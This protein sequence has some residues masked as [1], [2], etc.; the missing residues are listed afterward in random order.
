LINQNVSPFQFVSIREN[1]TGPFGPSGAQIPIQVNNLGYRSTDNLLYAVAMP[2]NGN[3]NYGIIQ[4]DSNGAVIPFMPA[5]TTNWPADV[6]LLAGDISDDG[7]TFYVNTY[8]SSTLYIVDL[9]TKTVTTKSLTGGPVSVADWAVNPDNGKLYGAEGIRAGASNAPIYELDPTS[10]PG[11]ITSLGEATGLPVNGSGNAAFYGGAWFNFDGT[12]FVYRNNDVIYEI[13]LSGPSVADT[14]PG[15]AGPSGLNDAAACAEEVIEKRPGEGDPVEVGIYKMSA[16]QLSF[17]INYN[18]PAAKIMDLVPAEFEVTE[19][20]EGGESIN[21]DYYP[22]CDSKNPNKTVTCATIIEWDV[23]GGF[24]S[25]EC[26][27]ETRKSNGNKKAVYK[28]TSCGDLWLN[29]GATA[30]QVDGDG[31]LV[32]D[33]GNPIPIL[34]TSNDLLVTAVA[35][36][37]P[38]APELLSV[39]PG[40]L[41]ELLLEWVDNDDDDVDKYNIYRSDNVNGPFQSDEFVTSVGGDTTTYLDTGL[42]NDTTYC[43]V[44]K[45][46]YADGNEGNESNE[47]CATTPPEPTP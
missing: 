24:S 19:C 33:G 8:P 47:I 3:F 20:V 41:G 45:A 38:C 31:N 35:G 36:T 22:D 42:A 21:A 23:G 34:E 10:T 29:D 44:I 5:S 11:V 12:F 27:V 7:S 46:E 28:P 30:Y 26:T 4:M 1:L 13:D 16:T 14:I 6:R 32:L 39:S 43:Y 17:T 9:E 2:V 15:G 37:K 18:G 25:L 40:N